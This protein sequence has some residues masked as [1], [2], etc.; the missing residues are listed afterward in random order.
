MM[1][2]ILLRIL[3]VT[4]V[5]TVVIIEIVRMSVGFGVVG[6]EGFLCG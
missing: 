6:I 5:I 3:I 2:P 4:E 1:I